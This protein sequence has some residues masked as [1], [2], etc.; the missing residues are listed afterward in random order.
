MQ[1]SKYLT[2]LMADGWNNLTIPVPKT[3][4]VNYPSSLINL[5]YFLVFPWIVTIQSKNDFDSL[6]FQ[7]KT[8]HKV[9]RKILT[10]CFIINII[11]RIKDPSINGGHENYIWIQ[12]LLRTLT[13]YAN[14]KSNKER[15]ENTQTKTKETKTC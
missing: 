1:K 10:R 3:T 6:K 14:K 5:K 9:H 7:K 13:C 4:P 2:T 12:K 15:E 11:A 8:L